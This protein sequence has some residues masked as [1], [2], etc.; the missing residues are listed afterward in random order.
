M[1]LIF[2]C[3]KTNF[4]N[5][6]GDANAMVHDGV[7]FIFVSDIKKV[8]NE[9]TVSAKTISLHLMISLAK[10][11]DLRSSLIEKRLRGTKRTP[12]C[13]F[14]FFVSIIL[15][16]DKSACLRKHSHFLKIRH[17]VTSVDLNIDLIRKWSFKKFEVLSQSIVCV[18]RLSLRSVVFEIRGEYL[19]PP[20]PPGHSE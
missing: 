17:V 12:H 11:I 9:K 5:G 18:Y 8:I 6:L 19:K 13:F 20:P 10:T 1:K 7:I 15:L 14:E 3:Q 2:Q 4:S 16:G